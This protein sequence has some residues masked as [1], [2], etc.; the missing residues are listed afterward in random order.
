MYAAM[1]SGEMGWGACVRSGALCGP[2]ETLWKPWRKAI[3]QN[4]RPSRPS[5]ATLTLSTL[6]SATTL[7]LPR[8]RE[9][10][11]CLKPTV[12]LVRRRPRVIAVTTF[13]RFITCRKFSL[14]CDRLWTA[15]PSPNLKFG[16]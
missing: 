15:T 8:V 1:S 5:L 13:C 7:T 9:G 3:P 4:C 10:H 6:G 11:T 12:S 14:S 2:S 16:A